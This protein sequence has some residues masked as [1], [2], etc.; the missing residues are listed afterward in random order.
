MLEDGK[1]AELVPF[2]QPEEIARVVESY[3]RQP[4]KFEAMSRASI[5]RYRQTFTRELHLDR[6]IPYI[7]N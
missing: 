5:S 3:I 1:V 2:D 4:S 7:L 6:L